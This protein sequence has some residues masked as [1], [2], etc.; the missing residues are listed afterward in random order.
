MVKDFNGMTTKELVIE[1]RKDIK[2]IKDI[3]V[4]NKTSLTWNWR[5]TWLLLTFFTGSAVSL[6]A[7][8]L[9]AASK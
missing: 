9:T 5:I 6:L 4:S 2:L 1:N 3:V 7:F 8:V